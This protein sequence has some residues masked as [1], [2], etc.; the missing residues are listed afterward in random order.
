MNRTHTWKGLEYEL[1]L[2]LFSCGALFGILY[3]EK[4]AHLLSLIPGSR[5][6]WFILIFALDASMIG[7]VLAWYTLP[8]NTLVFGLV[9]SFD[10]AEVSAL[11]P[12]DAW[13]QLILLLLTVP[14][15]FMLCAWSLQTA[16]K[17]RG[18]LFGRGY[19]KRVYLLSLFLMVLAYLVCALLLF[20][21]LRAI[22]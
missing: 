13:P 19:A 16:G 3:R 5:G 1:L 4:D 17:L 6:G 21:G 9:S 14:L 8:L 2:L 12:R 10:A 11:G 15:H 22:I 7:S 20:L 18:L